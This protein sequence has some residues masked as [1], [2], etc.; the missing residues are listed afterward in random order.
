MHITFRQTNYDS[1]DDSQMLAKWL[2]DPKIRHLAVPNSSEENY[3]TPETAEQI[4]ERAKEIATNNKIDLMVLEQGIPI[5]HCSILFN[6]H[7]RLIREGKVAWPGIAIGEEAY[8]QKG[9]GKK[10]VQHLEQLAIENNA[11]CIEVGLFEFNEPSLRLF[12][13]LGYE[14]FGRKE[15]ITYWNKKFWAD[16]RLLKRL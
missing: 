3:H 8:R 6:P 15:N 4:H 2:A 9:V 11:T 7:H 1:L 12:T 10:V 16:I 14:K 5:G 13:S